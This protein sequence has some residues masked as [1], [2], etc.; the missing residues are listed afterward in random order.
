MLSFFFSSSSHINYKVLIVFEQ[1][2]LLIN[3]LNA[4]HTILHTRVFW[5]L[6]IF[7]FPLINRI[8]S[9]ERKKKKNGHHLQST[10]LLISSLILAHWITSSWSLCLKIVST[11]S[12]RTNSI[13]AARFPV[14]RFVVMADVVPVLAVTAI[15]GVWK[16]DDAGDTMVVVRTLGNVSVDV[17]VTWRIITA[18]GQSWLVL[19]CCSSHI[20]N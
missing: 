19:C 3:F 5:W 18:R 20:T 13:L 4:W 1:S 17:T 8:N 15:D 9:S 6:C 2:C 12:N 7:F 14:V 10:Y 11:E 16:A